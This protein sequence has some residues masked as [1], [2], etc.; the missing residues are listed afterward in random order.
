MA[1]PATTNA[2][3]LPGNL[4][5]SAGGLKVEDLI[6]AFIKSVTAGGLVTFQ[7]ASGVE[8]TVQLTAAG[9]GA[10]VT[11][12][13]PDPTGGS[14]GDAYLQVS[15][16][17]VLQSVWLNE[18]GTWAEYTL[19]QAGITLS[20]TAPRSVSTSANA[21]GT[22]TEASRR[23]HHHQ[24]PAA[25]TTQA[26]IIE[27]A[28]AAEV[29]TGTATTR[30]VTPSGLTAG[31]DDRAA[32]GDP[33]PPATQA[34]PGSSTDFSREDHVHPGGAPGG[35]TLS[36]D[37]PESITTGASSEGTSDEASR[38]DHHHHVSI[39]S[40]TAHG[41]T[42]LGTNAQALDSSIQNRA[43]TPHS[44]DHALDDRASDDD[45][46]PAGTAAPGSSASTSRAD[47]VHP[48]GSAEGAA[49]SDELP[50]NIGPQSQQGDGA[51]ASR[52]D[53]THYL[54]HDSTLGFNAGVLG[55]SIA[56][57]VEHLQERVQYF[58]N[59][60]D[61]N[62]GGS[63]AGQI[64]TQS[65]YPKN[66]QRVTA[67]LTPPSNIDDAIYKAGLYVVDENR[68]IVSVLGQSPRL[69]AYHRTG[70]LQLRPDCRRRSRRA[71]NPACRD[72]AVPSC[73]D[74]PCRCR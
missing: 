37:D 23:D 28:T 7:N 53:H 41:V 36:D 6:G 43:I 62:T 25:T 10:T 35:V 34:A 30:A 48:P 71:R 16:S 57:V 26:G 3:V 65:R 17:D 44:L 45:P 5:F 54:P 15:A 69:G 27:T 31:L 74:P 64:Y 33:L 42:Q 13:T 20:D 70:H 46:L 38:A 4:L 61:Y 24:V 59:N 56:D 49:L 55:V 68:L 8:S 66:V 18:A 47:H 12:G 9:G 29:R 14:A 58:T 32:D 1:V 39:A 51:A 11:S 63:A 52:D 21:A 22:D 50:V 19:A 72:R 2:A 60:D 40:T 67:V 73:P